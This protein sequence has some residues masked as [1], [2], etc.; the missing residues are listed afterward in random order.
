LGLKSLAEW[1]S[2]AKSSLSISS[3]GLRYACFVLGEPSKI[4][5]RP[6]GTGHEIRTLGL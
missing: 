3:I 1:K 6:G 4:A 2:F 5:I